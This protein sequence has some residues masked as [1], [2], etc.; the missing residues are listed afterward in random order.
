M[1]VT[2]TGTITKAQVSQKNGKQYISI[3][4]KYPDGTRGLLSFSAEGVDLE[5]LPD[6]KRT[7]EIEM[8]GFEYNRSFV[9]TA[10]S[11]KVVDP[12]KQA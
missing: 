12:S 2:I 4:E 7:F 6:E 8:Q 9:L 10:K 1:K 11:I 3:G 5:K